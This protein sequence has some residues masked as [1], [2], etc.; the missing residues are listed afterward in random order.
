MQGTRGG[1][2]AE[3]TSQLQDAVQRQLSRLIQQLADLS[4]FRD[5][6]DEDEYV[7]TKVSEEGWGR[8]EAVGVKP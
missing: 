3:E 1:R 7:E 2:G 8:G 5:D 4:E 6:L